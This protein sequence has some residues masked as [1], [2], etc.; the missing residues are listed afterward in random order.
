MTVGPNGD[1]I[2]MDR[3]F[4][5]SYGVPTDGAVIVRPDGVVAWR[6]TPSD[7][8]AEEAIEAAMSRLLGRGERPRIRRTSRERQAQ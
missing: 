3:V 6:V 1:A 5:D 8:D 4:E 7:Q 2:A